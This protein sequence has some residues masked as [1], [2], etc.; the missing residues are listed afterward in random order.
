MTSDQQLHTDAP[1]PVAEH[2][3]VGSHGIEAVVTAAGAAVGAVAAD[4]ALE[5]VHSPGRSSQ[6]SSYRTADKSLSDSVG[7]PCW[8]DLRIGSVSRERE[9][10]TRAFG[11][12]QEGFKGTLRVTSSEMKMSGVWSC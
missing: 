9:K 5:A 11:L 7:M 2:V 8:M 10:S 6:R 12:S 1:W 3:P 4:D